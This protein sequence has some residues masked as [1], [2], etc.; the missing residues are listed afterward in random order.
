MKVSTECDRCGYDSAE[1][2]DCFG[3]RS[4][5]ICILRVACEQCGEYEIVTIE[6]ATA[7]CF[8][9]SEKCDSIDLELH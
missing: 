4:K 7:T 1:V 2:V 6:W 9:H 8:H 3:C 5:N